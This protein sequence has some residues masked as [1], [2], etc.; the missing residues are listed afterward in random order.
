MT[1]NAREIARH[2]TNQVRSGQI[3]SGYQL[4]DALGG[5]CRLLLRFLGIRIAENYPRQPTKWWI[6]Q[7]LSICDFRLD[8]SSVIVL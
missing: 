2:W 3:I 7:R 8:E 1:I 6:T 5:R 4:L